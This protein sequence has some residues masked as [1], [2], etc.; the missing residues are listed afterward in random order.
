MTEKDEEFNE[1]AAFL[2]FVQGNERWAAELLAK[3]IVY[4]QQ[5]KTNESKGDNN[6]QQRQD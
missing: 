6:V 2:E 5:A 1:V 4:G 3:E